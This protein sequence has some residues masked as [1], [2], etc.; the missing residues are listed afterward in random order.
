MVSSSM[1]DRSLTLATG[2]YRVKPAFQPNVPYI[3]A[4]ELTADYI[5][6][7]AEEDS[8]DSITEETVPTTDQLLQRLRSWTSSY[9]DIED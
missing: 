5:F 7:T 8:T 2:R 6:T 4:L 3:I 9:K 1:A